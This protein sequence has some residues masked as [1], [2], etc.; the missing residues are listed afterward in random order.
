M[1]DGVTAVINGVVLLLESVD[2]GILFKEVRA[3]RV[4]VTSSGFGGEARIACKCTNSAE[5]SVLCVVGK[6][7]DNDE[8]VMIRAVGSGLEVMVID[9]LMK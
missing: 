8:L 5:G 1:V 2:E 4:G 7:N 9:S 6:L 3:V